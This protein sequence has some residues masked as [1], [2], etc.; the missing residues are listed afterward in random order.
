MKR[1]RNRDPTH[2]DKQPNEEEKQARVGN[3]SIVLSDS[4]NALIYNYSGNLVFDGEIQ[5]GIY[6]LL[7]AR[8]TDTNWLANTDGLSLISIR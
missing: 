3:G 1:Y 5:N 2:G 6:D 7:R 8:A 4:S